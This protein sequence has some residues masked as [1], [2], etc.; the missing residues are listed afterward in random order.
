MKQAEI[1]AISKL[2]YL[3]WS[4]NNFLYSVEQSLIIYLT[5]YFVDVAPAL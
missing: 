1:T 2:K 3:P 4:Q 5:D